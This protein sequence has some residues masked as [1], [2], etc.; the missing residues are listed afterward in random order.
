[1]SKTSIIIR[2]IIRGVIAIAMV[3][4]LLP[5]ALFVT[6]WAPAFGGIGRG[7]GAL[8]VMAVIAIVGVL[9]T[10]IIMNTAAGR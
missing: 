6:D 4:A 7:L 9:V 5:F 10:R 3:S 8:L 1:M 2:N